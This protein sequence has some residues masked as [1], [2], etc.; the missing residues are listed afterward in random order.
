MIGRNQLSDT[1]YVL[2]ELIAA[3]TILLVLASM[4]VPLA[5]NEVIRNREFELREDLRTLREAIDKYKFY[6]D[7]GIIP[8]KADTFG[9]P[10]DLET[11]VDGVV[12][13]GTAKG[14]YKFLR[15]IPVDPMTGSADWGLRAMQDDPDSRSWG[16]A[17]VFDV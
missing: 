9:Y 7:N 8:V 17:N 6:S 1:G 2:I 15:R 12:I 11:L 16:G 14:K 5:R 13:K 3:I 4:A 10:P